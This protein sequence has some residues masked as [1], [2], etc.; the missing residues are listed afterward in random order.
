ML[1][2][3]WRPGLESVNA[4]S[5]P[6]VRPRAGKERQGVMAINQKDRLACSRMATTALDEAAREWPDCHDAHKKYISAT[7]KLFC[8]F[9]KGWYGPRPGIMKAFEEYRQAVPASNGRFNH[10]EVVEVRPNCM[11][12]TERA[13]R[14]RVVTIRIHPCRLI[15]QMQQREPALQCR[16]KWNSVGTLSG[17]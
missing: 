4:S 8:A 3:A 13:S 11:P 12:G 15:R 1:A 16:R 6:S 17:R 2:G 7:E 5:P 9:V 10:L 14:F